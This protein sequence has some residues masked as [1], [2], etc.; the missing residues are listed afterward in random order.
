LIPAPDGCLVAL[1]EA[2][3]RLSPPGRQRLEQASSLEVEV[4][5]AELNALVAFARLGGRARWV[6]RLAA[7]ALGRRIQAHALAHRVETMIDW[8]PAGRTGVYFVERGAIPRPGEVLYERMGSAATGLSP[9]CFDWSTALDG[10]AGFHT[11]GITLA[12]GDGPRA[13]ALEALAAA[14]RQGLITG[15]DLNYRMRLWSP[16]VAVRAVREALPLV[17]VFFATAFD[18]RLVLAMDGE[19][20]ALARAVR[21]RFGVGL[22]VVGARRQLEA[23][24]VEQQVTA[25]G[26]RVASSPDYRAEVVDPL[27]AGDALAG[28][29]WAARLA[30]ADLDQ[31]ADL[32]ARAAALKHTVP[33]DVLV[34]GPED[35]EALGPGPTRRTV[36]R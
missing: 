21:E 22:V 33:G 6:S 25:V 11:T 27:G 34:A 32:A 15:F 8:E 29:F 1:G 12:L 36:I 30:G 35:L 19:P 26:D 28:A 17:D 31:A 5:G 2:M 24:L 14:R 13:A 7:T 20:V 18:L 10:A 3:I 23:R 9:G 4:G 16:D